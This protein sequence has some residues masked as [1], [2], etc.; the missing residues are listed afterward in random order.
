MKVQGTAWKRAAIPVLAAALGGGGWW[1][2]RR[3]G[4][5]NGAA[6]PTA[7]VRRGELLEYVRC[8][9]KLWVKKAAYLRAPRNAQDLHILWLAPAG[10]PVRTGQVVIRFDSSELQE[11]MRE[12]QAEV[13][14]ATAQL[15]Q[16]HANA[17]LQADQ[18][19]LALAQAQVAVQE[20]RLEAARQAIL[21]FIDGAE[22]RLALH[23]AQ[24][25]L[26]VEEATIRQHQ[27]SAAASITRHREARMLAEA[28]LQRRQAIYAQTVLRAPVSGIITYMSNNRASFT[29][30]HTYQVGDQ[31][32]SGAI[33]A[34]IPVLSTLVMRG[35]LMQAERGQLQVG[36]TVQMHVNALP[37]RQFDGRLYAISP[38]TQVV[39][40]QGWPPPRYFLAYATLEHPDPRLRP[41]M[42]GDL[43]IITRRL[44]HALI[45]PAQALFIV[46]GKTVVYLRQGNGFRPHPIRVVGRNPNEIAIEGLTAGQTVALKRPGAKTPD[47][48]KGAAP[49]PGAQIS[50][51]ARL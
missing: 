40:G 47:H 13:H 38:L 30:P 33:I 37:D 3:Y 42:N 6:L 22:A 32:F 48:E 36:Q 27:Q 12:Q 2:W 10:K 20:A 19:R 15:R 34:E 28:K 17:K 43:E 5:R 24:A 4:D 18:D 16:S 51:G 41:Q 9:G 29:N 26:K 25:A 46:D 49:T 39:F 23:T 11:Q 21:S 7:V 45:L 1:G 31:V 44:P 50:G 35:N 8:E 14:S